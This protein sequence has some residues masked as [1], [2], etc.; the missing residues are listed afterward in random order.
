MSDLLPP[1]HDRQVAEA[2]SPVDISPHDHAVAE[3]LCTGMPQPTRQDLGLEYKPPPHLTSGTSPA[4]RH[5]RAGIKDGCQTPVSAVEQQLMAD[6]NLFKLQ[7]AA[8]GHPDPES[9]ARTQQNEERSASRSPRPSP[10]ERLPGTPRQ[11]LKSATGAK[12]F[13]EPPKSPSLKE[14]R[15]EGNTTKGS[16]ARLTTANFAVDRQAI[17]EGFQDKDERRRHRR[18]AGLDPDGASDGD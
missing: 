9:M 12:Q 16:G 11:Q 4:S 15:A 2:Y 7:Y 8:S 10:R 18:E 5:S 3:W 6:F 14:I 1:S 17:L 13:A